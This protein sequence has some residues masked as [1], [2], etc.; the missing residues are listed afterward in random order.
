MAL[1][2]KERR[3]KAR[4]ETIE[5]KRSEKAW[6]SVE[7]LGCSYEEAYQM[8]LDDEVI[9][10]GEPLPWELTPEQQKSIRKVRSAPRT[11][12]GPPKKRTH[13]V[14]NDKLG[15]MKNLMDSITSDD[16]IIVLNNEREFEFKYNGVKY[17]VTLSAPRK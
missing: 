12:N 15:L 10:R 2:Y 5:K 9:E 16:E 6:K 14:N 17:K 1:D 8:V 3:R 7:I 4:E 11:N 13:E